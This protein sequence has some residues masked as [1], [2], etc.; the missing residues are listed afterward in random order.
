MKA[1]I[2]ILTDLHYSQS[3][4]AFIS[5]RKGEF[6][7]VLL[8]RAVHRL[9]LYIKPDLVFIG[10]DLL[11][12]PAGEDRLELLAELK[13]MIDLIQAPTI[14][15]SGNHD[16]D[17]D[18]FQSIMGKQ[19]DFLDINGIRFVPF[20]D[21]EEPGYKALRIDDE[22][23]RMRKLGA[24]FD[25][26]LVSLQHVPLF[27]PKAESCAYNYT[28]ADEIV[29][30]MR[31][32]N[33]VL[34]LSGHYHEG[35]ELLD[36]EGVNCIVG[37]AL[38]EQPFGYE[39]IEIDDDG[40]LSCKHENLA[41]PKELGLVDHHVH[42]KFAYCSA[43]TDK[44]TLTRLID[45]GKIFNLDGIILSEHSA[46]LYFNRENYGQRLQFIEGIKSNKKDD[47]VAEYIALH[48]NEADDFCRLGIEIDYDQYGQMVIEPG[49]WDKIKFRNGSIHIL[50][51]ILEQQDMTKIEDEFLFQTNAVA[52]SGVDVL[53][54]PFRVFKRAGL[55]LPEHLFA[56]TVD[57][58]KRYGV[59]AEINYHT[60]EPP[61]EFFRMC[62]EKGIKL[63]FGSDAHKL[64]EVGEFY[65]H[66]KLLQKIAPNRD[67]RDLL[68]R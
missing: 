1:K 27:P 28:N 62:I 50:K 4:N 7:D 18:V 57:I 37:R 10:G 38:C 29:E 56:P 30:I 32:T 59:A 14:V 33:Y 61:P 53:V 39:L 21:M 25:G 22:L 34:A 17:K 60:N 13:E 26:P 51:N 44:M 40:K 24:E 35:F 47:H 36:Y 12:Q 55:T 65:P 3:K 67:P 5:E 48:A 6:A 41:V 31:E 63:S 11:D 45:I 66:L 20:C 68:I 16:P 46:H 9:N 49:D 64:Y 19:V 8:L 15:I 2:A 43:Y 52:S 54:H 42:T 23:A 58:L